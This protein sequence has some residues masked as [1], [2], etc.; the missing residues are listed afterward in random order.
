MAKGKVYLI[1]NVISMGTGEQV[2]PLQVREAIRRIKYFLVEDVRTA[3]RYISSLKLGVVIDELDFEVV[4]K[5]TSS[6]DLDQYMQRV[7]K[8][9]DVGVISESGCP[10]IADPG[11]NVVAWAHRNGVQNVPLSGPSSLFMALMASGFS[12][13]SFAFCG[14][15]PVKKPERKKALKRLEKESR[16]KH[17]TQLFIE[18]PYRNDHLLLDILNTCDP[19]T[20]LCVAKDVSGPE[21]FIKTDLVKNWKKK[22]PVLGKVPTVFLIQA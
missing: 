19:S 22:V 9:E 6:R 7:L 3:R 2:I 12:G 20:Q 16:D 11:A 4:D 10:G 17:Q 18:T 1:P 15:I 21:E 13:Q 5:R 14:Y 8:G